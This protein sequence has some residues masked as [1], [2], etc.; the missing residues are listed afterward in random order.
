ML[1][2][3]FTKFCEITQCNGHYAVQGHSRSPILV[4]IESSSRLPISDYRL[5]YTV[6]KVSL[7]LIIGHIFASESCVPHFNKWNINLCKKY[8]ISKYT[9]F[10]VFCTK[11]W[12]R[13]CT[14]ILA[15]QISHRR[16]PSKHAASKPNGH[17]LKL[18]T[19]WNKNRD[20][21]QQESAKKSW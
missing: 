18:E 7:W 10:C 21:E 11:F 8:S 15:L 17:F 1:V 5:F 4:P 19:S 20:A 2:H 3:R 12:S 6:S 13:F 14:G 16:V 9:R